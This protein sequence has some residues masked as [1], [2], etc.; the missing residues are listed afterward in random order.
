MK[1]FYFYTLSAT[2]VATS[3]LIAMMHSTEIKVSDECIVE[4]G[5]IAQGKELKNLTSSPGT[6]FTFVAAS[7]SSPAYITASSHVPRVNAQASAGIFAVLGPDYERVLG[8]RA[9]SMTVSAR[10]NRAYAL[11]EFD[12]GYFTAGAGDSGWKTRKLT[13]VWR[14][15]VLYFTPTS[16]QSEPDIDYLGIWPGVR[17]EKKLM[18]LRYIKVKVLDK[19]MNSNSKCSDA[20]N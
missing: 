1:D 16:S 3:I 14:D 18:D 5:F 9:L 8:G 15:Y 10:K 20:N 12:M 2:F 17:G 4:N 19:T 7:Q 11:D 6:S 13:N